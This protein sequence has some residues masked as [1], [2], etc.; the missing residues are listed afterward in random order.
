MS[1]ISVLIQES[2]NGEDLNREFE[3]YCNGSLQEEDLSDELKKIIE[4]VVKS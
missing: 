4:T 1:N 3:A 2:P